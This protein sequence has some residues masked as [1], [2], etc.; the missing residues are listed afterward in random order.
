MKKRT[1]DWLGFMFD[2]LNAFCGFCPMPV[3]TPEMVAD[4]FEDWVN[5]GDI[6][7]FNVACMVIPSIHI[8]LPVNPLNRRIKPRVI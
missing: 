2:D 1:V 6:D 8:E 4:V 3:G 5:N 7:G